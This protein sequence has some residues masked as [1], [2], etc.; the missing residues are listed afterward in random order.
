MLRAYT[1]TLMYYSMTHTY[2]HTIHMHMHT[3]LYSCSMAQEFSASETYNHNHC[4]QLCKT[5]PTPCHTA[6]PSSAHRPRNEAHLLLPALLILLATLCIISGTRDTW[7][8]AGRG[9]FRLAHGSREG[10]LVGEL[11]RYA[12][13]PSISPSVLR[14]V[15]AYLRTHETHALTAAVCGEQWLAWRLGARLAMTRRL[16]GGKPWPPTQ[17]VEDESESEEAI[18]LEEEEEDAQHEGPGGSEA[19]VVHQKQG[20]E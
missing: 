3:Y 19:F 16:R 10:G 12:I 15:T 18:V 5:L 2:A 9:R 20:N 14:R 6:H 4:K 13:S 8:N 1:N 7:E 11:G 17:E